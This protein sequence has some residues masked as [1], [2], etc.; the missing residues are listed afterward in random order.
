ME[1]VVADAPRF[2]RQLRVDPSEPKLEA[3]Y[4]GA[5]AKKQHLVEEFGH[6]AMI[7]G[8]SRRVLPQLRYTST[9]RPAKSAWFCSAIRRHICGWRSRSEV[10]NCQSSDSTR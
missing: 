4:F 6:T 2:V 5:Q 7:A 1:I 8:L 10:M 3:R 9:P